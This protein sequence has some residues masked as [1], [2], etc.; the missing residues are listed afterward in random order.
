MASA[1]QWMWLA[2][3]SVQNGVDEAH[4]LYQIY[5]S[6]VAPQ[7]KVQIYKQSTHR[8]VLLAEAFALCCLQSCS[9][10]VVVHTPKWGQFKISQDELSLEFHNLIQWYKEVSK[11][12]SDW[13]A[14][15]P[16]FV[17]TQWKQVRQ[18]IQKEQDDCPVLM[19]SLQEC[20]FPDNA[21][22]GIF[23]KPT[24]DETLAA[25]TEVISSKE[26]LQTL[27]KA[28]Q[29]DAISIIDLL[30]GLMNIVEDKSR[31]HTR[32]FHTLRKMCGELGKLPTVYYLPKPEGGPLPSQPLKDNPEGGTTGRLHH[33]HLTSTHPSI[34]SI[35]RHMQIIHDR[36]METRSRNTGVDGHQEDL[37][38]VGEHPMAS[39]GFADVWLGRYMKQQTFC[40][41]AVLWRRLSHPNITPFIGIDE[42]NFP[43]SAVCKWMPNGNIAAYLKDSPGANR[44]ELLVD[45]AQ[46]LEYLHSRGVLHGDIKG[47]NILIDERLHACL[48][49][50][51]L[52]AVTYDPN[53]VNAISTSSSVNGSIRWMAPELL[54]PE[55]AGLEHAR[56]SAESD[57]YSLAMVMWEVYTG[58]IPFYNLTRDATVVFRVILGIRPERPTAAT[59]LGLS[60]DIWNLME[61]GWCPQWQRR[62]RI[63][64]V[65]EILRESLQRYGLFGTQPQA[66][67]LPDHGSVHSSQSDSPVNDQSIGLPGNQ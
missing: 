7:K 28:R 55:E 26:H 41:E 67:P 65:L 54:N 56:P 11:C 57:I 33:H 10:E 22:R 19:K 16:I 5:L 45:I 17:L 20:M 31:L 3:T 13:A 47:A 21:T 30:D 32:L 29:Q 61:H 52:S 23:T 62:P 12:L 64:H 51:G 40:R 63:K 14:W 58:R 25:V 42:K 43:F 44:P 4:D 18:K 60:D 35:S 48:A 39:G 49:D 36:A 66:W 53:T 46:G 2:R 38:I 27:F 59:S 6:M 8:L 24:L 9:M 37:V 15:D 1:G 50:F 34:L